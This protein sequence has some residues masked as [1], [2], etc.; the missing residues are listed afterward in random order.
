MNVGDVVWGLAYVLAAILFILYVTRAFQFFQ[1]RSLVEIMK[2]SPKYAFCEGIGA[3]HFSK[4]HIRKIPTD[5][6]LKLGGGI[7]TPSLC[8]HV[9]LTYGWDLSVPIDEYHLEHACRTCVEAYLTEMR[10]TISSPVVSKG[11]S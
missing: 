6:I 5:E 9:K 3:N 11:V 4:W 2:T 10:E 8:G 7:T 1:R